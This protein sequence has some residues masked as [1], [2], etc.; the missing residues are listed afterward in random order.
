MVTFLMD[1]AELVVGLLP[2][3]SADLDISV[4]S[5]GLMVTV[6]A[7]GMMVGAPLMA[8]ATLRLPRRF[9]LIASLLVFAAGHVI[10]ALSPTFA[11]ALIGRFVSALATGTFWAVGAVVATAAAG[12]A[13]SSRVMGVVI[14]GVTLANIVGG[15]RC[16]LRTHRAGTQRARPRRGGRNG[17]GP[18]LVV[19]AR[20]RAARGRRAA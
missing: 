7:I 18:R 20:P 19:R 8:M 2:E 5:A 9:T 14:G 1:T 6:F 12:P 3:I 13:A 10:G 15:R 11:L 4:S 17:R 16:D